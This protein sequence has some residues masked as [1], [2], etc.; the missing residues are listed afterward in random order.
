[1]RQGAAQRESPPATPPPKLRNAPW[2]ARAAARDARTSLPC[3]STSAGFSTTTVCLG[4][5]CGRCC[6]CWCCALGPA[7]PA[8]GAAAPGAC[9]CSVTGVTMWQTEHLTDRAPVGNISVTL[10]PVQRTWPYTGTCGRRMPPR[11]CMA[12]G[13]PVG[14][15]AQ[16]AA[17][18][19]QGGRVGG[20]GAA[21]LQ[22]IG[23]A[24]GLGC[25]GGSIMPTTNLGDGAAEG[26]LHAVRAAW[27]GQQH[28][29][30]VT[31][32]LLRVGGVGC[33]RRT[34]TCQG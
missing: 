19:V 26:A 3:A 15:A 32:D 14:D 8:C 20:Q 25:T 21:A 13:A 1:M 28:P 31:H 29:A 23:V 18:A 22:H 17:G 16:G 10:Q 9:G 24:P 2:G 7:P 30:A 34:R 6:C 5:C 33:R 12:G 27:V 4:G 11:R